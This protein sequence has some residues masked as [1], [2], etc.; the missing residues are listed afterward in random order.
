MM[1]RD[2]SFLAVAIFLG[3]SLFT[4]AA[5][6]RDPERAKTIFGGGLQDMSEGNYERACPAFADSLRLDPLPGTA[7][8]LAVCESR[9]GHVA[10]AQTRYRDFLAIA[11]ALPPKDKKKQSERLKV[12]REQIDKLETVIPTLTLRL[13]PGAPAKTVVKRNDQMLGEADLGVA[14]RVDPGIYTISTEAPGVP[15][16]KT[17]IVLDKGERK[18]VVLDLFPA[19]DS[20]PKAAPPISTRKTAGLLLGGFGVAGLAAGAI[21]TALAFEQKAVLDEH[22]GAK[23]GETTPTLCDTMGKNAAQS[24][25]Q[26]NLASTIAFAAGGLGLGLGIILVATAPKSA[27]REVEGKSITLGVLAA[28]PWGAL[29]GVRGN[30]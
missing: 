4:S 24:I 5:D 30:W 11:E 10:T 18:T 1:L 2:C 25:G 28:G 7:F 29:A 8:T 16:K 23:I 27:P 26:L 15:S 22:C 9:W 12:A 14:T 19:S 17:Q 21:T 6:A 20:A 3:A 13:G